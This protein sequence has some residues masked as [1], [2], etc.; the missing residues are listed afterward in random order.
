MKNKFEKLSESVLQIK[1]G[2]K[3]QAKKNL[4]YLTNKL[5]DLD[6][7]LDLQYF[8]F[9]S[10]LSKRLDDKF[11]LENIYLRKYEDISQ[12][13]L[14]ELLSTH[15]PFVSLTHP[16]ANELIC[17]IIEER[18]S[19]ILLNIGIGKGLQEVE[20]LERLTKKG[21]KPEQI[22][23]IGIEP[24]QE[25]LLQAELNILKAADQLKFNLKFISIT[26]LI[27]DLTEQEWLK[28]ANLPGDL[29]INE[30]F[31]LHH[32][33]NRQQNIDTRQQVI[34][35]LHQLN[36]IAFILVEPNCDHNVSDLW[37]RFKNAWENYRLGFKVIDKLD[38]PKACKFSLKK[39]FFGREIEDVLGNSEETRCERHETVDIW[40]QRLYKAGFKPSKFLTVSNDFSHPAVEISIKN[41]YIGIE[42]EGTALITIICVQNDREIL[43]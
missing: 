35:K 32:V 8:L 23:V 11:S 21:I 26:K 4:A 36:P 15:V 22:T 2:A 3:E 25:N 6:E 12:I 18:S 42:C 37:Y 16:I 41:T 27:E 29:I 19:I 33:V 20:L 30:A 14:F 17:Q 10:A 38:I 43:D 13:D 28:L 39:H 34:S 24:S 5:L 40:L 31:S 1:L 9:A 7:P